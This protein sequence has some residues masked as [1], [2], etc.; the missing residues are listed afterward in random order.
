MP[1]LMNIMLMNIIRLSV[2]VTVDYSTPPPPPV[3]TLLSG[4]PV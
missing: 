2:L 1:Q 3:F 4:V